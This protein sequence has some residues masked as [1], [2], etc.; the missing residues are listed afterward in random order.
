[1]TYLL[2]A[3]VFIQAKNL[4]YGLDFCPAFWDW[5]IDSN[6]A[7]RVFSIDKVADEIAAGADELTDW[8]RERANGLFRKTDPHI[9][10]QFG[11]VSTWATSQR[12]EPAAINT[13]LQVADFYLV[14]H[15]L[16]DSHIV[17]THE[18]PAN[19]TKRIKI[20]NA[21]IG[22]DLRFMTPYEMLRR[23]RARFVLGGV[24]T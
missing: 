4:H 18:V 6:A 10:T 19:S 16:A 22:L 17:V 1:M 21:C 3:N 13:F 9:A 8:M 20:P 15:A 11:K 7:G 5:L 12:Y 24:P 2:D 23:E 14:A